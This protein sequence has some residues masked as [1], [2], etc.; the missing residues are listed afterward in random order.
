MVVGTNWAGMKDCGRFLVMAKDA[1]GLMGFG[2][3]KCYLSNFVY[4]QEE[5]AGG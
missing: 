3:W 1:H 5:E 4:T 2:H